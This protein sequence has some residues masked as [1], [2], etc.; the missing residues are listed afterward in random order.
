VACVG[1]LFYYITST[2]YRLLNRLLL[3]CTKS[4]NQLQLIHSLRQFR[5]RHASMTRFI[6]HYNRR[7]LSR[8]VYYFLVTN[9]F[10]NVYLIVFL[11]F[12]TISRLHKIVFIAFLTMQ[13]SIPICGI[14]P[15]IKINQLIVSSACLLYK[16]QFSANLNHRSWMR[17]Q[18]LVHKY[19]NVIYYEMLS[20]SKKRL[21]SLTVGPWGRVTWN[22]MMQF[23]VLYSGYVMTF[24][25]KFMNVDNRIKSNKSGKI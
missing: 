2:E 12:H 4:T 21:I 1:I 23:V 3:K 5:S 18:L 11:F 25:S 10:C 14:V 9:F 6:I 8:V 16:L 17:G 22:S 15:V 13:M 24:C 20:L 7:M 19:K